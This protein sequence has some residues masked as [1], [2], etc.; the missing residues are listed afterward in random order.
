[1]RY[2]IDCNLNHLFENSLLKAINNKNMSECF[3]QVS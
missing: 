2:G 1:M 3:L